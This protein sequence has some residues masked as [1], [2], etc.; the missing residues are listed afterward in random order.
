MFSATDRKL[1]TILVGIKF[2][3]DVSLNIVF[4]IETI[5]KNNIK[6]EKK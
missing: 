2:S 3:K 5:S 1:R 4:W 6:L